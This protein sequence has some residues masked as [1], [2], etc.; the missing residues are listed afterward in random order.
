MGRDIVE[1]KSPFQ[2]YSFFSYQ[3]ILCIILRLY[4][5]YFPIRPGVRS[6]LTVRVIRVFIYFLH[7]VNEHTSTVHVLKFFSH[8]Y[9][10]NCKL[11]GKGRRQSFKADFF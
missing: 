9:K 6:V 4:S 2:V 11:V 5:G 1:N 10:R 8:Y 3:Y 7:A